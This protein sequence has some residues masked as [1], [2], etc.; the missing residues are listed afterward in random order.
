MYDKIG[1]ISFG[2]GVAV[3]F[4]APLVKRLM[5]LDSLRDDDVGDDL[6]GQQEAGLEAQEAG[7]HPQTER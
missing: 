4:V 3:I 6:L 2:L 1:W 5:H 7:M